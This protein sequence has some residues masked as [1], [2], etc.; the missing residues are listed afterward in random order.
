MCEQ[1]VNGRIEK[2]SKDN[3]PCADGGRK[4][5]GKV[6]RGKVLQSKED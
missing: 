5:N 1:E 2:E 3:D 6:L 4:S